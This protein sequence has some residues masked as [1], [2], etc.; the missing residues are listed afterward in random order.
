MRNRVFLPIERPNSG[1]AFGGRAPWL[2]SRAAAL[3]VTHFPSILHIRAC[4][5]CMKCVCRYPLCVFDN[6]ARP[7][8]M[9]RRRYVAVVAVITSALWHRER[10]KPTNWRNVSTIS[11]TQCQTFC[12]TMLIRQTPW[13]STKVAEEQSMN[14]FSHF[15]PAPAQKMARIQCVRGRQDGGVKV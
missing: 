11:D 1:R 12:V 3:V 15:R 13:S 10:S 8:M 14:Q 9:R 4:A 5:A 6:F 7:T 2:F